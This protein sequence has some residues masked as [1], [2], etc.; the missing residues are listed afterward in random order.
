MTRSG[1]VLL[2][3][4]SQKN[5]RDDFCNGIIYMNTLYYFWDEYPRL[6]AL[7]RSEESR[8]R[9]IAKGENPDNIFTSLCSLSDSQRDLFEGTVTPYDP[10]AL[11]LGSSMK[12]GLFCDPVLRAEGYRYC[13]VAC[14]Y[15]LDCT[16]S[17]SPNKCKTVA[18]DV[19]KQMDEF[20]KYVIVIINEKEFINRIRKAVNAC[21]F[22]AAPHNC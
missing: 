8:A 19:P 12:D 22:K 17:S 21:G 13:N 11:N 20:G 15:R 3:F 9:A 14:F 4:F 7:K 5:Y 2:K 6:Q 1:H 10:D 18:Y 16:I